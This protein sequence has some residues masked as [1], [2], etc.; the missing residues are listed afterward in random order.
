MK[1]KQSL[2]YHQ[3][4]TNKTI[5]Q[6]RTFD[7][8]VSEHITDNINILSNF[9]EENLTLKCANNSLCKFEGIDTFEGSIKWFWHQIKKNVLY[10]K[11]INKNLLNGIKLSKKKKKKKNIGHYQWYDRSNMFTKKTFFIFIY[12]LI[13]NI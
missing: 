13:F 10:S 7:T 4:L 9:K 11:D 8:D 6:Y 2:V 12:Y 1:I 3:L 5:K